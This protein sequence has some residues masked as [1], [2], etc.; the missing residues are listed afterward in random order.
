MNSCRKRA[1]ARCAGH[2]HEDN[3]CAVHLCRCGWITVRRS[4]AASGPPRSSTM[5]ASDFSV[6]PGSAP[7][8]ALHAVT[9]VVVAHLAGE[10]HD[11]A[12][13]VTTVGQPVMFCPLSLKRAGLP[14]FGL[15]AIL[16]PVNL[17]EVGH[18]HPLR[19]VDG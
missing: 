17:A 8:S 7:A 2:A 19:L 15:S 11:R 12:V 5:A 6:M 16:T 18:S 3:L 1:A 9:E 13:F 14:E 10:R 4:R